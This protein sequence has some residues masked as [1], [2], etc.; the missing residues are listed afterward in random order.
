[1]CVQRIKKKLNLKHLQQDHDN[2]FSVAFQ[3][4][5]ISSVS[6]SNVEVTKTFSD[7]GEIPGNGLK[8][9]M[10][11]DPY[12]VSEVKQHFIV[13]QVPRKKKKLSK[14]LVLI[15]SFQE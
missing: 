12:N 4:G 13:F 5:Y 8:F 15:H 6:F 2:F 10:S 14:A 11:L 7:M 1:M 9:A 3:V